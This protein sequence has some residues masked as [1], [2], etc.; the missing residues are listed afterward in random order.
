MKPVPG[1]KKSLTLSPGARLKCSGTISAHCNLHLPGSS[2]SPASASRVAGTTGIRH[3]SQLIFV[4]LVE[5]GFHHVGQD[6]LDLLTSGTAIKYSDRVKTGVTGEQIWLQINEPTPNDKG[7][8][9][10]ELFDGKTG[11]QKTVDL[12]GQAYDEAYAEFQRLKQAAI[13]EKSAV[14]HTCNPSNLGGRGRQITGGQ[15]FKTS[16]ANMVKPCSLLKIQ[17]LAGNDRARVLGGLP[18]VVTIQEGKSNK[19]KV[20]ISQFSDW[21]QWLMPVIPALWEAK[22]GGSPEALNL[23]CNVWGDPAPEV[24][25]LKNEK[26]LASD[27]HCTLKFEAGK[28]AYFTITGVSTADS[29]KYGLVVKNKYGSE[30]SDFTVSVFIPEE[31]AR[32]AALESQKGGKKAKQVLD[33]TAMT[34]N[35]EHE[36]DAVFSLPGSRFVTQAGVQCR[37]WL[38]VA[39][40]SWAQHFGKP[41]RADHL[42]STVRDQPGQYGES[43]DSTKNTKNIWAWWQAPVIPATRKAE[44]GELFEPGRRR[45]QFISNTSGKSPTALTSEQT[46]P[47]VTEVNWEMGFCCVAQTNLELLGPNDSPALALKV[48]VLQHFGRPRQVDHLR[49]EV[50][51]Q[52]GQHGE[53]TS[54]LKI[55]KLARHGRRLKRKTMWRSRETVAMWKPRREVQGEA[56]TT[57]TLISDFQLQNHKAPYLAPA[58]NSAQQGWWTSVMGHLTSGLEC[59]GMI[60]THC[61]LELLGLRN[62]PALASR[63]AGSTSMHLHTQRQGLTMLPKLILNSWPQPILPPCPPREARIRAQILVVNDGGF[64]MLVRLV[65]NSG[66]QMIRLPWPP[67]CLD[68]RCEPPRPAPFLSF[69]L[70]FLYLFLSFSLF[71]LFLTESCSVTQAEMPWQDLRSL[72]PPPPRLK[73]FLSLNPLSSWTTGAFSVPLPPHPALL[74]QDPKTPGTVPGSTA[75][76]QLRAPVMSI[77]N[78]FVLVDM[79]FHHVGQAGLELLTSS[80]L[81]AS[82]F[83]NVGITGMSHHTHHCYY[84]NIGSTYIAQDGLKLLGSMDPP[85]SASQSAGITAQMLQ[86]QGS[87]KRDGNGSILLNNNNNILLQNSCYA[88]SHYMCVIGRIKEYTEEKQQYLRLYLCL[89]GDNRKR[90]GFAMLARLVSNSSSQVIHPPRPPKVLGLQHFGR[91]RQ[92]DDLRSGVQDWPGQRGKTLSLLKAQKLAK[93]ETEFCHPAQAGPKLLGSNDPPALTSQSAGITATVS[94]SVTLVGVQ[95][96]DLG[97]LQ[98]PPSG[99]KQFSCLS[100]LS[101]LDYRHVPPRPA[102]FCIFSRDR[103]SPYWLGWFQTPDLRHCGKPQGTVA[104]VH[105]GQ[106]ITSIRTQLQNN[107]HVIETLCRAKF[108]FPGRQKIHISKWSFIMFNANKSE[109]MVAEKGLIPDGCGVKCIPS[110]GPLDKRQALN[111]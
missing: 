15:E 66:P 81:P 70:F 76:G 30:T 85:T 60:I 88:S 62:P 63:V 41:R 68:Y 99:F 74:L 12:S 87:G 110:H 67:K 93:R 11:H 50:P 73:Q 31:E 61:S 29:G 83:Q 92:V 98:P 32:M 9:I 6:G 103:V 3:H 102:N 45:L 69:F 105:T 53:T 82:A 14:A 5:T 101:I 90:Q 13:A 18:D 72:Q 58:Y 59:S 28:T 108:K 109:D 16:L 100:L 77:S 95:W 97:L 25:W 21:V 64:T 96:C 42:R 36:Q 23:T 107:K 54:L 55:Q 35:T 10:M 106:V 37:E 94:C 75:P 79:A 22:A 111:S 2:N 57:N 19:Q 86:D 43:P 48:L 4:F 52:P 56:N 27:D 80:D 89:T 49:S 7:K 17:K 1:A 46:L 78:A 39:S 71:F 33:A 47:E 34:L 40:T 20:K 38:T 24:S 26:A 44:A 91:L 104:G 8:Y 84:Y 65:L 51:D